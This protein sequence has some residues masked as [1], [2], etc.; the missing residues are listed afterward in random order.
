MGVSGSDKCLEGKQNRG[1]PDRARGSVDGAALWRRSLRSRDLSRR[2]PL[3]GHTWQ[4]PEAFW[5]VL[6]GEGLGGSSQTGGSPLNRGPADTQ[7][8]L[9]FITIIT[10]III[11]IWWD[12]P[13]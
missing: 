12:G 2:V 1:R 10:I 9:A 8:A 3:L 13:C 5:V 4:Y 7:V 11:I 6:L